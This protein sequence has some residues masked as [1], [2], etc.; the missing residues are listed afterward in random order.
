MPD[1]IRTNP[2]LHL[3]SYFSGTVEAA[4]ELAR[5]ELGEDAFL[6]H[7]REAT[8]ETRHYG[9]YEVVFGVA[10]TPVPPPLPP[11]IFADPVTRLTEDIADLRRQMHA[12]L[13]RDLPEVR[14]EE[15]AQLERVTTE[16]TLGQ[17]GRSSARV[18]L[19]GP[20]GVGKTST[21]VKLAARYGVH[22]NKV[23]Q[24]VTTDT[25]RV[26]AAD[27]LQTLAAIL[28]A[29]CDVIE[30]P[31]MLDRALEEHSD[32]DLV[33]IDTP[34]F[35]IDELSQGLELVRAASACEDLDVHLV[36]SASMKPADV[37]RLAEAYSIFRPNKLIFTRLDETLDHSSLVE[38]AAHLNLPV[39]FLS[40]GQRIPEDIE[41]ATRR[42]LAELI[43]GASGARGAARSAQRKGANA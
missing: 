25:Y 17:A 34:G 5:R 16:A 21:L 12:L 7:A 1:P 31:S 10:A 20:P 33:L 35:G 38:V 42:R 4:I 26:A 43:S 2:S 41:P 19:V 3:K 37:L 24:I 30:P 18:M 27:Q 8:P 28:G 32:K 6:I 36:L 13:S 14:T 11:Q 23:T 29:L 9:T 22:L 39:S 40:T 15:S